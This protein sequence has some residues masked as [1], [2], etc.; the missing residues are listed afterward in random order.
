MIGP[1]GAEVWKLPQPLLDALPE[2]ERW[3]VWVECITRMA[4]DAD[5]VVLPLAN[6]QWQRRKQQLTELGGS[7][8]EL[9][10]QSDSSVAGS[11]EWS[12]LEIG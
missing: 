12:G 11:G 6:E 4:M 1:F 3:R 9:E 5:G 8:V 2:L 7:P 10:V